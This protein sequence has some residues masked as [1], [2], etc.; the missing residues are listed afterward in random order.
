MLN[1]VEGTRLREAAKRQHFI[2]YSLG[3]ALECA[4]CLDIA[5]IKGFLT[6]AGALADK[7]FLC[8]IGVAQMLSVMARQ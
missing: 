7:R 3:S 1:L 2:E 8:E 4:A 5:V 6:E